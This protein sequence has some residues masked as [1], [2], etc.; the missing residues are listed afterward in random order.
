MCFVSGEWGEKVKPSQFKV[1]EFFS[2][3]HE[4]RQQFIAERK[5]ILDK[6]AKVQAQQRKFEAE[7][8]RKEEKQRRRKDEKLRKQKAKEMKKQ[9]RAKMQ[10]SVAFG[11][12]VNGGGRKRKKKHRKRNK[13]DKMLDEMGDAH[14]YLAKLRTNRKKNA[15]HHGIGG[16]KKSMFFKARRSLLLDEVAIEDMMK[17][18]SE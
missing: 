2:V 10:K 8:R 5:K 15:K 7:E 9:A 6:E 13:T 17:E 12:E 1:E 4:F 3:F 14:K 18:E 16:R 11:D